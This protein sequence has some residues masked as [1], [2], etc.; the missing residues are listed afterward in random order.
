MTPSWLTAF[1]DLAPAD[2]DAGVAFWRA[3]TGY[4]VS[5]ARGE[6]GQ[7]AT[8]VPPDGDGYLRTQRLGDGPSGHHLDLHVADPRAAA[9]RAVGLGAV[10]VDD[11]GD[12]VV[13]RSPAGLPFCTVPEQGTRRP[14][15]AAWPDGRRS[16]VDQVALDL[17]PSSYDEECAFWA[18]LTGFTPGTV[19]PG[20]EFRRLDGPGALRLLLQRLDAGRAPGFH[21]D[22]AADDRAT[23]VERH[24]ALGARRRVDGRGWTVLEAPYGVPYCITDRP[25]GTQG[26]RP[27]T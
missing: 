3:V 17:P 2:H 8:L 6:H 18:D 15:P 5:P 27:G 25:P 1:V 11:Q 21:L 10:E 26:P 9:D 20:L 22:L 7:F 23:E 13:L 14:L 12:V 19:R 4:A 16:Q 24:L